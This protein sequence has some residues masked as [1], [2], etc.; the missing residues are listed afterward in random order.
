M[1]APGPCRALLMMV[2]E[3]EGGV[4]K[5]VARLALIRSTTSTVRRRQT[6]SRTS[7]PY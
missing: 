1:A 4:K 2:V 7:L 6:P 5:E 3:D